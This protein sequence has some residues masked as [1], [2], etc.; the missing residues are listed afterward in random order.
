MAESSFE[1]I[2][3][4]ISKSP[5]IIEKISSITK[6]ASSTN[7]YESLPE[8]MSAI[9]P[10]LQ[11]EGGKQNEEKE[12]RNMEKTDTPPEKNDFGELGLPIGKIAEKITKNSK[13]L[14]ALKPYLN[15]ERSEIIDTVLKLA[16]VTDLMKLIK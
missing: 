16:Q 12:G 4:K 6:N 2:L 8:I 14:L 5:D 11:D 9:A 1:E 3:E 15:R 7:P 13:L 10:A